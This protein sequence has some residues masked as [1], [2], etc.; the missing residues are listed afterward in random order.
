MTPEGKLEVCDNGWGIA[1]PDQ[2]FVFERFWRRDR[3]KS[4]NAGLGLAIVARIAEAH[5][6]RVTLRSDPGRETTFAIQFEQAPPPSPY[7]PLPEAPR[8]R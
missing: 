7:P 2:R 4:A 5:R 8:S 3:G 1:A 6:T